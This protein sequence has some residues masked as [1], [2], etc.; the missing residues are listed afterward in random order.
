MEQSRSPQ[1]PGRAERLQ[2]QSLRHPRQLKAQH[3]QGS[4]QKNR[5]MPAAAACGVFPRES[6]AAAAPRSMAGWTQAPRWLA[7]SPGAPCGGLVSRASDQ[8]QNHGERVSMDR[9]GRGRLP[10]A[11]L[12]KARLTLPVFPL[13]NVKSCLHFRKPNRGPKAFRTEPVMK[14]QWAWTQIPETGADPEMEGM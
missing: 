1:W 11:K 7:S 14:P 2:V 4:R 5:G 6:P 3:P 10:S 8:R 13:S 12:A 9:G